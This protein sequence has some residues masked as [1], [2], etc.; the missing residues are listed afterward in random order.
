MPTYYRF[1]KEAVALID[2][3]K[4]RRQVAGEIVSFLRE[5]FTNHKPVVE[6]LCKKMA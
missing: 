5:N 2:D 3:F 1:R 4:N 6:V